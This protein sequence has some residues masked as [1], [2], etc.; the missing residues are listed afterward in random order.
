MLM[1][2]CEP[3]DQPEILWSAAS[4]Y[5]PHWRTD[6]SLIS[7]NQTDKIKAKWLLSAIAL[8]SFSISSHYVRC[9]RDQLLLSFL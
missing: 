6:L 8:L 3:E 1:S 9:R 4:L 5:I 7:S 2:R